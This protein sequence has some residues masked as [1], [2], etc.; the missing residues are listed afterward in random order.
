MKRVTAT[1]PRYELH[2]DDMDETY[3]IKKVETIGPFASR[4][5]ARQYMLDLSAERKAAVARV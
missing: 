3:S 4:E 2:F 5:D 1:E